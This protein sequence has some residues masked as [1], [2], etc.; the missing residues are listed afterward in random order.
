MEAAST[1]APAHA[2]GHRADTLP[3][4]TRRPART[5][6]TEQHMRALAK[7]NEIRLARAALKRAVASG[8]RTVDG[9]I[10]ECPHESESM[11]IG[12]LLASQR[13][14]GKKRSRRF[15]TAIGV[16]ENKELGSLTERQRRVIVATLRAKATGAP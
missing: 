5:E 15:L 4:R 10:L 7:A 12:E 3:Q 9:V 8:A 2:T 11:S 13:R 16:T 6:A 14:W 1:F